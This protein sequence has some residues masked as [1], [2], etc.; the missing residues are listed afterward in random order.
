[1]VR[2]KRTEMPSLER[3]IPRAEAPFIPTARSSGDTTMQTKGSSRP[4]LGPGQSV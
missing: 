2:T 3:T 1:M 4:D